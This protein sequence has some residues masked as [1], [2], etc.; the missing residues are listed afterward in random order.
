MFRAPEA[1]LRKLAALA[2]LGLAACYDSVTWGLVVDEGT[3]ETRPPT[4][5]E[6]YGALRNG[7]GSMAVAILRQVHE[8]RSPDEL[9][10]FAT[11][12]GDVLTEPPAPDGDDPHRRSAAS[13]L[14][15]ALIR[16]QTYGERYRPAFDQFVR[17]FET[18]AERVADGGRDPIYVAHRRGDR[19]TVL[20]LE[21]ALRDIHRAEPNGRGK[22]YLRR[23]AASSRPPPPCRRTPGVVPP[24]YTPDLSI[25]PCPNRSTWCIAVGRFMIARDGNL[26]RPSRR[27]LRNAPDPDLYDRLCGMRVH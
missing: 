12:V 8:K 27:F 2:I 15:G 21:S 9:L 20:S 6:A 16:W 24:G 22:H 14:H 13:A 26:R 5:D 18:L 19:R 10:A 25:P 1:N 23:L 7:D 3:G 4:T 11:R 17:V